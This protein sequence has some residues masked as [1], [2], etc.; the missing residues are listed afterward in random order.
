MSAESTP[1][2]PFWR[3]NWRGASAGTR[4][5]FVY[6]LVVRPVFY[7]SAL[8]GA[9]LVVI[10]TLPRVDAFIRW[11]NVEYETLSSIHAGYDV[12]LV[13]QRLGVPTQTQGLG[14]GM[15]ELIYVRRD[16][17]VQLVT[18]E[19]GRVLL[20]AVTSCDEEFQPTF[21]GP[22]GISIR[23]QDRALAQVAVFNKESSTYDA[24]ALEI[25][26]A[27]LNRRGLNYMPGV[28]GSTPEHYIES[29]GV[30]SVASR[31]RG[32]F[33]G[34]NALCMDPSKLKYFEPYVGGAAKAPREA[35][36]LRKRYAANTYAET[37]PPLPAR[38]DEFGFIAGLRV[39]IGVSSYGLPPSVETRAGS[40]RQTGG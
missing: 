28:T 24:K 40:T 19:A 13:E 39:G 23:L 18:D 11:R 4:V 37:A 31:D 29:W 6:R 5:W 32:Y 3:W 22:E 25:K 26:D 14:G 27:D 30:G 7:L 17:F 8:I 36:E 33:V 2:R 12:A 16:H 35:Q 38:L 10:D 15:E 21:D 9:L 20:Y 1:P 34:I